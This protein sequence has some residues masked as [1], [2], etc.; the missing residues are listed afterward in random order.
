MQFNLVPSDYRSCSGIK[1]N[2]S[3][4]DRKPEGGKIRRG[5]VAKKSDLWDK[6]WDYKVIIC[7]IYRREKKG[8]AREK[9]KS[10]V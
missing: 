3:A 5:R 7:T 2:L 1:I 8:F 4:N 9:I 10:G 6:S